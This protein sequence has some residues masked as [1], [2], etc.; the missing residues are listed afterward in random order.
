MEYNPIRNFPQ[1]YTFKQATDKIKKKMK[2]GQTLKFKGIYYIVLR[3]NNNFSSKC[4][5]CFMLS[6]K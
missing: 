4:F 6:L 3:K 1:I 5:L 2:N